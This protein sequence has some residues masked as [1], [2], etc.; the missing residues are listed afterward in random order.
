MIDEKTIGAA[1]SRDIGAGEKVEAELDAFVS[2][3]DKQ[4]RRTEG[5]RPDEE[6]WSTRFETD[7]GLVWD[8]CQ[9]WTSSAGDGFAYDGEGLREAS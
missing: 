9:V 8:E 6:A 2:R 3:R 4:R 5:E 7:H 1:L